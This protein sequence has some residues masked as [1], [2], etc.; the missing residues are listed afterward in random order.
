MNWKKLKSLQIKRALNVS[1]ANSWDDAKSNPIDDI[2]AASEALSKCESFYMKSMRWLYG[3]HLE[4]TR[5]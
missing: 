2:R 3:K 1:P 4:E 5:N